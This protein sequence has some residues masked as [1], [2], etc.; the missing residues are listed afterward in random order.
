ML[1]G[2]DP[3]RDV[4][5]DSLPETLA[6]GPIRDHPGVVANPHDSPILGDQPVLRFIGR[7]GRDG[8][9]HDTQ[10]PFAVVRM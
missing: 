4:E 3:A 7:R 2:V 5:H 8:R 10:D 9:V 1:L 6:A